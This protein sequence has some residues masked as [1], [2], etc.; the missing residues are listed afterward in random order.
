MAV[1][2]PVRTATDAAADAGRI[3]PARVSVSSFDGCSTRYSS[4]GSSEMS[5]CFSRSS[6]VERYSQPPGI[7]DPLQELLCPLLAGLREDLTG[8]PFLENPALVEEADAVRNVP[9][10]SHLVGCDQ[11]R[12]ASLRKLA[13]HLQHLGD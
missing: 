7:D 1:T 12:H 13:D 6:M 2:M 5:M 4:S 8:S 11:H 10:E 9:G 3:R